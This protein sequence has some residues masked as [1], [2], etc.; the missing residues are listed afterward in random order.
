MVYYKK[1]K[2]RK[3][4]TLSSRAGGSTHNG[5]VETQPEQE[6]KIA[7]EH[8]ERNADEENLNKE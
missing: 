2:G 3:R 8:Q 1:Q 6:D 5:Q 4:R 7:G